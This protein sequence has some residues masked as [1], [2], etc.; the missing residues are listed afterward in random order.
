MAWNIMEPPGHWRPG[1]G[2]PDVQTALRQRAE[3]FEG[4]GVVFFRE[5]N[6]SSNI[7]RQTAM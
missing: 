7:F 1:F 2:A 4:A 6:M 5:D 3:W